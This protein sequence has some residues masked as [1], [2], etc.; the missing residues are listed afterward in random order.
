MALSGHRDYG[1]ECPLA[2]AKR[3]WL[4]PTEFVSGR[5]IRGS[6][7]VPPRVPEIGWFTEGC[8]TLDLKEAKML[9]QALA[10]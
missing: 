3:T 2:G 10:S 9:L 6:S 8:D 1:A 4:W 5:F 7:A